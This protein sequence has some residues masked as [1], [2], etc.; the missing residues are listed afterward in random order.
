MKSKNGVDEMDDGLVEIDGRKLVF[1]NGD[2][3]RWEHCFEELR[4]CCAA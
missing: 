2:R 1:A 4:L 3:A